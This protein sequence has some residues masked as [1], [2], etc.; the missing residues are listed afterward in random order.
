VR[1]WTFDVNE[2]AR[3]GGSWRQE[4]P[5]PVDRRSPMERLVAAVAAAIKKDHR[6]VESV[7]QKTG[8]D[9]ECRRRLAA[10]H[11]EYRDLFDRWLKGLREGWAPAAPQVR[12][13]YLQRGPRWAR[14]VSFVQTLAELRQE[15]PVPYQRYIQEQRNHNGYQSWGIRCG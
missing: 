5:A 10:L 9:D 11:N 6:L 7:L 3:D 14:Y 13:E 4:R 8:P 1:V 15:Y 2:A 12:A